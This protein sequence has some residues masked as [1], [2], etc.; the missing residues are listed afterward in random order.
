MSNQA[1]VFAENL[2]I[3]ANVTALTITA[4]NKVSHQEDVE[5]NAASRDLMVARIQSRLANNLRS[6]QRN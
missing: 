2:S 4:L 3:V 5:L 1:V 6:Q